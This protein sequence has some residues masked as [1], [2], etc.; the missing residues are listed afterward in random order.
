MDQE[1]TTEV[2]VSVVI[3]CLNEE[4]SIGKTVDA[5]LAGISRL[6]VPGE[7]IVV[8][9][10]STDHSAQIAR[11]HGARVVPQTLKG[12][13]AAIRKGFDSA[14]HGI[15]V[16][17]DGDLTYDFTRLDELVR[18]IMEGKADFVV[19][20]RMHNIRPGAMPGLH[21]YVGTPFLSLVLRLM[22]RNNSVRD[23][24]CGMRA[25][26]RNTYRKLRCATT[27]ME[28]ASEMIIQAIRNNV[29]MFERD[30]VYHPRVGESKLRS[31]ADGWRHLRFMLLYSPTVLFLGPGIF[32]WIAGLLLS[33]PLAFGPIMIGERQFDI[34]F[35]IMGGLLNIASIQVI[36]IGMLSKAYAHLSGLHHDQAVVWFYR[37]FS[38]EKLSIVALSL[39]GI[40]LVVV[41]EI[42][43]K[44]I[45]SGFGTL[46]DARPLFFALLLLV[47]GVQLG[48][49]GYL[50]SIMALPRHLD[51]ASPETR[52]T[53]IADQ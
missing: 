46:H 14:R 32:F 39:I 29:R 5:A 43:C 9:N 15:M 40:G 18:P 35:M 27:G 28:F 30:I 53:E 49:A 33:A 42:V 44:W 25:I 21:R 38:F 52:D 26:S 13:G 10:G 31:F 34:H 6:G 3:P 7:V 22:F 47:N 11:E 36:T 8:D 51:T 24:N 23:P 17:G 50:F 2:G 4:E 48:A 1:Q 19:G 45:A 16:M 20:N 41:V 37:R 12:Y